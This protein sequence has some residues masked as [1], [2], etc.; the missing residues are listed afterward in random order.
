MKKL[1]EIKKLYRFKDLPGK[2]DS[3]QKAVGRLEKKLNDISLKNENSIHD[4]EFQVYSQWGEDGIIQHLIGKVEI[5]NKIF[6]EFGVEDYKEA[7][8]RFLLQNNN[9]SG[10]VMDA[11]ENNIQKIKSDAIYWRYNLKAEC[12]FIDKDNI[13]DIIKRNGISGDIGILSIDIDGND[14]WIWNAI[15]CISP[16]IVI[17]EYDSLLGSKKAVTTPYDKTFHRS[18]AHYS[19]LYGGASIKALNNLAEK[20]GY[21]LAGSNSVGLNLFFVRK[22]VAQNIK[23]VSV[24]EA[25]VKAIFRNSRDENGNLSYLSLDEGRKLIGDLPVFDI[26]ENKEIKIKGLTF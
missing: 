15:D 11:S 16:R 1:E 23:P 25:Y 10:L 13:N 4:Y 21:V 26:E 8:T 24:E 5:P 12:C 18:K 20:K 14:Y 9:W 2:I 7:N 19:F 3:L 6:I 22:D 17:C